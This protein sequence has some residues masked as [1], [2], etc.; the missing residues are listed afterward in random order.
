[1]K[2]KKILTLT[3]I[4]TMLMT[5]LCSCGKKAANTPS[6]DAQKALDEGKSAFEIYTIAE[7]QT[8][9]LKAY[10]AKMTEII[11][12]EYPAAS[13]VPKSQ[14]NM[15]T[16]R[17][18]DLTDADNPITFYEIT[19]TRDG[20]TL[21]HNLSYHKDGVTYY[22]D[23]EKK[24]Y[25]DQPAETIIPSFENSA[26]FELTEEIFNGAKIENTTSGGICISLTSS[27]PSLLELAAKFLP[28]ELSG[29]KNVVL[30]LQI[31]CRGYLASLTFD[32]ST[33]NEN[34]KSSSVVNIEFAD[35]GKKPTIT[36]PDLTQFP[37]FEEYQAT[38]DTA[39]VTA[40]ATET[41]AETTS[42]SAS[43]DGWGELSDKDGEAID[44][45]FE[46]FDEN[47]NKKPN[48]D[49]LYKA[50][51]DKYGKDMIDSIIEVIVM[52]AQVNE[53]K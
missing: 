43:D 39:E 4:A 17:Q 25:Y 34:G 26:I 41:A 22:D 50:A 14:I 27:D 15:E 7:K 18:A 36:P 48:Y 47:Y 32:L 3:L 24:Y 16:I 49:E 19:Y 1:M 46:L 12:I 9:S 11:E 51:C 30:T 13:A 28:S 21:T 5:A 20:E 2:L 53:A 45:A 44:A 40:E 37:S 23:G 29:L 6:S 33:E 8:N 42:A 35:P 52:F 31:D 38:T 10:S